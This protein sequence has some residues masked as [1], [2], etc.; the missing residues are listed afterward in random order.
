[1]IMFSFLLFSQVCLSQVL[2]PTLSLMLCTRRLQ[3]LTFSEVHSEFNFTSI[4]GV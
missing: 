4:D 1:M 2:L 3:R